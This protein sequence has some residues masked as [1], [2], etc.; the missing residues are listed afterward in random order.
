MMIFARA[1]RREFTASAL[2]VFVALFAI[3]ISTVLIRILGQAAGGKVPSEAVLALLGFGAINYLPILFSLAIF[4]GV[5]LSMSRAWR[6][7]EMVVWFA[8]GQPVTAW[9][10]PV[11]RFSLPVALVVAVLSLLLSPWAQMRNAEYRALIDNQDDVA[12]VV[13]G[14]FRESA[15]GER[16]FFVEALSGDA[17][18]IRNVFVSS[19]QN[20]RLGVMVSDTGYTSTAPNGDRFIVLEKGRRYEGLPGSA[21]YRVMEFERYHLRIETKAIPTE[22]QSAKALPVWDLVQQP[23]DANMGELVWRIGLPLMAIILPLSAVPMS[24]VNPRAGR[25]S[26]MLLAILTYLVYSNG[27]SLAQAAV[28]QGKLPFI[29][30]IWVAHAAMVALIGLMFAFRMATFISWP[31][32]RARG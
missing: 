10:K 26:N 15:N 29:T 14:M 12:R 17:S 13:P 24:F 27:L 19:M 20:G 32:R 9:F 18:Q 21:D 30:G 28:A 31:W 25:S 11:L 6:D 8:S 5:L 2:A 3:L 23:T 22:P 4:M 1:L 7:S 16:V